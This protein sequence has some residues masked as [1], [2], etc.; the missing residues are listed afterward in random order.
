V[1]GHKFTESEEIARKNKQH[2][3]NRL[4]INDLR[5]YIYTRGSY[6][7]INKKVKSVKT[8]CRDCGD[9]LES[10]YTKS[11]GFCAVCY[12]K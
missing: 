7:I 9:L 2:D 8:T 6:L 4:I 11:L 12:N 10:S 5:P 1:V 3:Y